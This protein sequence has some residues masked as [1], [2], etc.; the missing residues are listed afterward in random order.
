[1][2]IVATVQN[3]RQSARKA[4]SGHSRLHD[5]DEGPCVGSGIN[6]VTTTCISQGSLTAR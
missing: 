2:E 6:G 1:M 4:A 3:S 5:R